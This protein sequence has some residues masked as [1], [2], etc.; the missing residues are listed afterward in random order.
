MSKQLETTLKERKQQTLA[1]IW[2]GGSQSPKLKTSL[3]LTKSIVSRV[4]SGQ[5]HIAKGCDVNSNVCLTSIN[6]VQRK[7]GQ[8]LKLI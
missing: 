1:S 2:S 4:I 8:D 3:R 7:C 6:N 5:K